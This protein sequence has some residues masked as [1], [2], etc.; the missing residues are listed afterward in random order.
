MK[1]QTLLLTSKLNDNFVRWH[2]FIYREAAHSD[3][4]LGNIKKEFC[5]AHAANPNDGILKSMGPNTAVKW[6]FT[7]KYISFR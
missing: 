3:G 2:I 4:G 5:L 1:E 7:Q 6:K